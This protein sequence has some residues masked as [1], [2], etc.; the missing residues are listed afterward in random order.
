LHPIR[1]VLSARDEH[2]KLWH[3][4]NDGPCDADAGAVWYGKI[5]VDA[6]YIHLGATTEKFINIFCIDCPSQT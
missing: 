5:A 1:D 6:L 2:V 3:V 4:V